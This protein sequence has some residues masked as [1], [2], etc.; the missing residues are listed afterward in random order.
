GGGGG[1]G[2]GVGGPPV[3][4]AGGGRG[5]GGTSAGAVGVEDQS[6]SAQVRLGQVDTVKH[7]RE[8][9]LSLR[10]FVG[11]SVAA[12]STSDLSRESVSRLVDEAGSLAPITSPHELSGLPDAPEPAAPVP[13]L[14]LADP[15]GHDLDPEAK[16]ELARRCEAAALAAD[17]RITNSEGGDFGDRRARYAYATS[18]GFHGEY[19]TSSFSISASPVAVQGGE[20]QRDSWY[21]VSRKRAAL[22]SP[23]AVGRVAASRALRRL[24]ARRGHNTPRPRVLRP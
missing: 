3:G 9:H 14:D 17:P 15:T 24:G 20:M 21:H 1:P 5:R 8:Q 18:H 23:E 2:R 10:V 4:L 13:S 11:Q 6:F 19:E 22:D 16:I 12:A 7:A